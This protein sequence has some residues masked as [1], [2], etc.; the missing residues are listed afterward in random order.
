MEVFDHEYRPNRVNSWF[1]ILIKSHDL[2]DESPLAHHVN[3]LKKNVLGRNF[4]LGRKSVNS[5]SKW[6]DQISV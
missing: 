5:G 1:I 4:R 6:V 3:I 2:I